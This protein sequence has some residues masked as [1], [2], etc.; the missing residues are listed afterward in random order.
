MAQK[1]GVREVRLVW[2]TE[3]GNYRN[4]DMHMMDRIASALAQ[5]RNANIGIAFYDET[6]TRL[7]RIE[8]GEPSEEMKKV[9]DIEFSD[10]NEEVIGA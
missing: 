3:G 1:Q 7:R 8:F 2:E 6:G 10:D 4:T 9:M 5:V